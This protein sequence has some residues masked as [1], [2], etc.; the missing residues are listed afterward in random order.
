MLALSGVNIRTEP[1]TINVSSNLSLVSEGLYLL[2]A[3][4]PLFTEHSDFVDFYVDVA[5]PKSLRRWYRPK[6]FFSHDGMMPFK[7]LPQKQAL[8]VFEWGLNWCVATSAHQY[9]MIHAAV[10]EKGGKALI[11]PAPPGSGKSTLCAALVS[12]GWRLLSD[13]MALIDRGTGLVAPAPRPISLKNESIC[14][15]K[16]YAPNFIFGPESDETHKGKV[17]HIKPPKNAVDEGAVPVEAAVVLFPKYK[18]MS[19]TLIQPRSR[20]LTAIE[21]AEN[22]F[23]FNILGKEGFELL[24]KT[25]AGCDCYSLVYSDL[26][27]VIDQLEQLMCTEPDGKRASVNG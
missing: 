4:Y 17:S 6:V 13:E 15:I 3:D 11:M 9:L 27:D 12:K 26:D 7:P 18:A 25:V 8:P 20:A 19:E 24:T 10:I 23:N 14:V 2:Y 22:A 21:L 1:F 5:A 16:E